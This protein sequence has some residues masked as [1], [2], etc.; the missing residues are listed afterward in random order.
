MINKMAKNL[1]CLKAAWKADTGVTAQG[2]LRC[3][4]LSCAN[5][6]LPSLTLERKVLITS[7]S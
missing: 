6:P 7:L 1:D 4:G 2:T 5:V 3:D